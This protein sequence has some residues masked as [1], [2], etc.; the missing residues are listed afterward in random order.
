MKNKGKQ[1]YVNSVLITSK[2]LFPKYK[3]ISKKTTSIETNT[4]STFRMSLKIFK[5]YSSK[6]HRGREE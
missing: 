6:G 5:E 4:V 2:L 3:T 1:Q